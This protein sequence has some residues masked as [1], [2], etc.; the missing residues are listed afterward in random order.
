MIVYWSL[1]YE[2]RY[3]CNLFIRVLSNISV[4]IWVRYIVYS[5]VKI[6]ATFCSQHPDLF[7]LTFHFC[8][9]VNFFVFFD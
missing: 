6:I 1:L 7:L 8:F 9:R 4:L 3:F 5:Y 2:S